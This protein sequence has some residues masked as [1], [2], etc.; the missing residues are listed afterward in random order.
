MDFIKIAGEKREVVLI[1]KDVNKFIKTFNNYYVLATQKARQDE[2]Q[3]L[4]KINEEKDHEKKM[5]MMNKV[6]KFI[7]DQISKVSF[8]YFIIEDIIWKIL[9]KHE[10][11]KFRN[12]F[13]R[14]SKKKM[15]DSIRVDEYQPIVDFVGSKI[16]NLSGYNKKKDRAV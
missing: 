6:I 10:R 7:E 13:G 9:P 12:I 14:V 11:K 8:P 3:Y 2:D 1:R 15:I 16:L 4:M 5:E